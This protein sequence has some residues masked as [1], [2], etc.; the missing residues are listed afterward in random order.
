MLRAWILFSC[1]VLSVLFRIFSEDTEEYFKFFNGKPFPFSDHL[2]DKHSY[3]YFAMELL[4]AIGYS[5]CIL[6]R[7]NT[8]K[9]FLWLF[10]AI[11]VLDLIHFILFK[12]DPGPGWNIIKCSL[13]G[14][15]LI[16]YEIKTR[17]THFNQ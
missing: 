13:F 7:D 12:R 8:P 2:L 11:T 9:S 16:L 3:T 14:V 6:I 5:W 1:L 15:P 17:W 4:I 10:M